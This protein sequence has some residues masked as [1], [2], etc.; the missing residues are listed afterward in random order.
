MRLVLFEGEL[1]VVVYVLIQWFQERP[2]TLDGIVNSWKVVVR[3]ISTFHRRALLV[4]RNEDEAVCFHS[5]CAPFSARRN[6]GV[7]A[8]TRG[9]NSKPT[10][11][12][13][14]RSP[15]NG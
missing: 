9:A 7:L 12:S 8:M 15:M 2:E 1:G 11:W 14:P 10:Q 13:M 5:S 4:A 3:A 6:I